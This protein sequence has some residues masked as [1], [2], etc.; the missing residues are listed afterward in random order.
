MRWDVVGLGVGWVGVCWG[1]MK[2]KEL[3]RPNISPADSN[4]LLNANIW[5]MFGFQALVGAALKSSASALSNAVSTSIWEQ[6]AEEWSACKGELESA[7]LMLYDPV[8]AGALLAFGI[9][10]VSP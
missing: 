9:A 3:R 6:R 2:W 5:P 10:D 7:R 8:W 4:S 1:G